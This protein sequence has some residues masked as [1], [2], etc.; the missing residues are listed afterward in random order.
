MTGNRELLL[1]KSNRRINLVIYAMIRYRMFF[2]KIVIYDKEGRLAR[3]QKQNARMICTLFS[4]Y[5]W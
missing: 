1:S 4:Y 2:L 3:W 5:N